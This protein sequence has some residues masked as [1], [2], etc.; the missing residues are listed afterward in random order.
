MTK[1]ELC[2]KC[3]RPLW[4]KLCGYCRG[5]DKIKADLLD[6]A[7]KGEFEDMRREVENYFKTF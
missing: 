3:S 1:V 5:I 7:N 2:E 4:E 6:I